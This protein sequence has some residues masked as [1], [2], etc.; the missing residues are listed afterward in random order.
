MVGEVTKNRKLADSALAEVKKRTPQDG[1][2]A[3]PGD[4]ALRNPHAT[5]LPKS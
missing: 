2:P 5:A 3:V 1:A 4:S